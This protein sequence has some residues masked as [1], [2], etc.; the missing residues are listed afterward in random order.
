MNI[1]KS[2]SLKLLNI[3]PRMMRPGSSGRL[4]NILVIAIVA[5]CIS[6]CYFMTM[7]IEPKL[8]FFI[9]SFELPNAQKVTVGKGSNVCFNDVQHDYL[10]ITSN[11][12]GTFTWEVNNAYQDTLMYFKINDSNP[13]KH[14]IRN[15]AKQTVSVRLSETDEPLTFTGA[16]IWNEWENCFDKQQD[17][18]IRHF[19]AR[20]GFMHK[21]NSDE[22]RL[23]WKAHCADKGIRSFFEKTDNGI[24]L[25]ILDNK[26]FIRD[27]EGEENVGYIRKGTTSLNTAEHADR[28]KIQFF[29]VTDHSYM[30][31]ETDNGTFQIDGVNYVMKASVKLS[32]WG[33]GHVMLERTAEGNIAVHYPKA[34]GYVGTLDTLYNNCNKTCH[35]FTLKQNEHTFPVGT[36]IYLPQISSSIPQDICNVQMKGGYNVYLHDSDNMQDSTKIEK[37]KTAFLPFSIIPSLKPVTLH[38]G[39]TT[40]HCRAGFIDS[41]FAWTYMLIPLI[42]AILL[43]ALVL[44][45]WSPVRLNTDDITD[46]PYYSIPQLNRYPAYFS[47]LIIIATVYCVCK[48]LIALKLSYTYPYFEKMTGI[49][50]ATTALMLI[51]F[52]TMAMILNYKMTEALEGDRDE[53]YGD[54]ST[55]YTWRKWIAWTIVTALFVGVGY[56]FFAVLDPAVSAEVI[57]SYFPSQI[58]DINP[59]HWRDAFGINDT[60]RS[61]PYT[62]MLIESL[63]LIFWFLQN[64]YFHS[65]SLKN[66]VDELWD[67]FKEKVREVSKNIWVRSLEWTK[68]KIS[69]AT[70]IAKDKTE[71]IRKNSAWKKASFT[72]SSAKRFVHKHFIVSLAILIGL[73]FAAFFI[74]AL[75]KPLIVLA[76]IWAVICLWDAFVLAVKAL[77]PGHLILLFMLATVG[78]M[79][80]NFGTAFI[81]IA[82]IIGMC[83]ALSG[84]KFDDEDDRLGKLTNQNGSGNSSEQKNSKSQKLKNSKY[85]NRNFDTRHIVFFEMLIISLVYIGCAMVADNGYITNYIGFLLTVLCFYFIIDKN[86]S[87]LMQSDEDAERESKWV[88]WLLAFACVLFITLPT[89]CSKMFSTDEVN[90]SRMSR[91]IMLYSNFEDLQSSGY[92]YAE[93]DAEFM[94]IMSH[95]MQNNEGNDPLSNEDHFLHSSV[96]TGQSPVVLN[97]LSVPIAFIGSYGVIRSSTVYFLLLFALLILVVQFSMGYETTEGWE[98]F[99]THAMQWRLLALFMWIGTSFYIYMSYIGQVPF[100]GRLNPGFGVDAVGE[101]LESAI[102]LAFMAVVTVRKENFNS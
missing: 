13:Q 59:L 34:L 64:C 24:V 33:A 71:N 43:I 70:D 85:E 47:L 11:G 56:L 75:S 27:N 7:S 58:Y 36:D 87:F 19:V 55:R 83:K 14:S 39:G 29:N 62:M 45:P 92:R 80:G 46:F 41:S 88:R 73:I 40:L 100:T 65:L 57:K 97:D 96:S 9:D 49:T 12:D 101:A 68:E 79:L 99:L 78:P 23:Q 50:P 35:F 84:V 86:S 26:T 54:E 32:E 28:C 66:K 21:S 63:L 81:T 6:I 52:F 61:V 4:I 22:E 2:L 3:F 15:D 91:R 30:D 1:F 74:N 94:T 38:S 72:I 16:A 10:T 95:Y 37:V 98:S 42:V 89:L 44:C 67:S 77:F 8:A 69:P 31:G 76:M 82:V 20:Y 5:V 25:V 18:L 48:S 17:V 93:S 60:H 90:Y 102:L 51:L 53:L